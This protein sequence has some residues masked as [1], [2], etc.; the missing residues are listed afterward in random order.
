MP[1]GPCVEP[2]ASPPV[3]EAV[4]H[5][6]LNFKVFASVLCIQ[7]VQ[8]EEQIVEASLRVAVESTF[9]AQIAEEVPTVLYQEKVVE[10]RPCNTC[11]T[12]ARVL[13]QADSLACAWQLKEL[14]NMSVFSLLAVAGAQDPGDYSS[15]AGSAC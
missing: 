13:F 2:C 15:E 9:S 6:R 4:K 10:A 5:F 1:V 12:Y 11:C 7:K 8:I 3:Q 14:P